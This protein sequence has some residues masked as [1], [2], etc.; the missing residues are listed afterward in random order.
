MRGPRDCWYCG[1]S[2]HK[3]KD[4]WTQKNNKRDKPKGDKEENVVSNKSKVDAL[5]LS[6]ESVDDSSVLDFGA[7]FHVTPH[8]VILLIM[9]KGILGLFIKGIMNPNRLLER[10]KL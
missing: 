9:S 2:G 3:K 5:L 7:S 10:G 6:L 8:R 4:F 1:K